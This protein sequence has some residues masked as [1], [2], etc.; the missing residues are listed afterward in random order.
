M[1]YLDPSRIQDQT[2]QYMESGVDRISAAIFFRLE[3]VLKQPGLPV[4]EIDNQADLP[5]DFEAWLTYPT[6]LSG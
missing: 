4:T 6:A 5:H 2:Y 3:V 1:T